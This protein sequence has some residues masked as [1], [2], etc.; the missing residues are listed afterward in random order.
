MG[1]KDKGG[2]NTKTVATKDLKQKRLDKKAKRTAA[3]A[4]RN[5]AV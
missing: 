5:R 4:K 1:N 2:K 3:E